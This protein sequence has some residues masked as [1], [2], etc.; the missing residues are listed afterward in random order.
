MLYELRE[1]E[2]P[3]HFRFHSRLLLYEQRA[4]CCRETSSGHSRR[5]RLIVVVEIVLR[6]NGGRL[7]WLCRLVS[8]RLLRRFEF[9]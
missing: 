9:P 3:A 4:F 2:H 5:I 8:R 6:V 7:C 1:R